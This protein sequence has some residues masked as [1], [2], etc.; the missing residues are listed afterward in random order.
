VQPFDKTVAL[1]T[2]DFRDA[3]LD[4]FELQEQLVGIVIRSTAEFPPVVA[5]HRG[6][7]RLVPDG[8][9]QYIGVECMHR[10]HRQLV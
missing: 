3:A 7:G 9:G 6:D 4:A 8:G 2:P 1:R 10:R 5:Q